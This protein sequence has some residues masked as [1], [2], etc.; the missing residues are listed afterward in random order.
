MIK[1]PKITKY[2]NVFILMLFFPESNGL[3]GY[4]SETKLLM[5][6]DYGGSFREKLCIKCFSLNR[7]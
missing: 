7:Y 4:I 1:T 2:R 6:K 3:N 5:K